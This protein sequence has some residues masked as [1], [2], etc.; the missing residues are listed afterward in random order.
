M[1]AWL[2][3]ILR[4]G[5]DRLYCPERGTIWCP[6]NVDGGSAREG[7]INDRRV[8][9]Y[10]I[11]AAGGGK[12]ARNNDRGLGVSSLD[13]RG[14]ATVTLTESQIEAM[15]KDSEETIRREQEILKQLKAE[16]HR[17]EAVKIMR[18]VIS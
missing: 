5:R 17:L 7:Q 10:D 2:E 6:L 3:H 4:R 16:R 14:E 13:D 15:I 9:R 8:A 18:V 11:T 12:C 1:H